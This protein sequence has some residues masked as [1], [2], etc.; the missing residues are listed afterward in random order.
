MIYQL[1]RLTTIYFL[2]SIAKC[3]ALDGAWDLLPSPN[4]F[5]YITN[6]ITL[7]FKR[8]ANTEG[9]ISN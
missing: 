2:L 4:Q 5:K 6:S 9:M 3:F 1:S 8:Q 7:Q